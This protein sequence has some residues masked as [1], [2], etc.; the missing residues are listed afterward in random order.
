[1]ILNDNIIA[2]TLLI[3]FFKQKTSYTCG[4]TALEMVFSFFGKKLTQSQLAEEGHTNKNFGTSHKDMINT[5][6]K[7]GFFCY[8]NENSSIE[9]IKHLLS[10]KLPVIIDFT[11]SGE[12]HYSVVSGISSRKIIL[13]DPWE[14]KNT[15]LSIKNFTDRWHDNLTKSKGWI[16]ALSKECFKLGKQYF[17]TNL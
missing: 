5:A 13:N 9:E 1:M 15:T 12:G 2:M 3:P 6:C 10:V 8:V 17:P 11:E 7:E 4:P 16:M 14:G